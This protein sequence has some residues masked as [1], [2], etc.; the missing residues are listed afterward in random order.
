MSSPL[1]RTRPCALAD[2]AHDRLHGRRLAGAV[3]AHQRHHLAAADLE[4][5]V[6]KN[7]RGAVPGAQA[8]RPRAWLRSWRALRARRR[9][10]RCR[11][12]PRALAALSRIDAASP[13][14]ISRPRASTMMRSAKANTTSIECSVNSTEMPRSTTSRLTSSISSWRSRARH[15][16]G[17]LVHQQQTRLVGERDGEFDALDVAVGE[18]AAR[19]VGGVAHAD[20]RRA[21]RARARDAARAAGRHSR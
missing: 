1:K 4:G 19:P 9:S 17:R 21:A 18:L 6:V 12:R 13:S 2:Q 15:A 20:L 14:A 5:K 8:S 11:N 16:G 3:A 7:A 10:C